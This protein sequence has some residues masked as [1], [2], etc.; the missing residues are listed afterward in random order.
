MKHLLL[1]CC[2]LFAF[3]SYAQKSDFSIYA[4]PS[5]NYRTLTIDNDSPITLNSV[6]LNKEEDSYDVKATIGLSYRLWLTSKNAISIGIEYS[7]LGYYEPNA[8]YTFPSE[9][10][11]NGGFIQ[12]MDEE[13]NFAIQTISVPVSFQRSLFKK[14][15][16]SFS[17]RASAVPSYIV[18]QK[19]ES[20]YSLEGSSERITYGLEG[21]ND[22]DA[23][24]FGIRGGLIFQYEIYNKC[25]ISVEPIMTYFLTSLKDSGTS[26]NLINTGGL[27]GIGVKL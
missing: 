22:F 7:N 8:F 24:Q 19:R 4:G 13:I 16:L 27:I 2:L 6:G 5:V 12:K 23:F 9:H 1:S 11:G 3:Q 15:R 10:N 26:E 20:T 14:K 17:A 21:R 25:F 18:S